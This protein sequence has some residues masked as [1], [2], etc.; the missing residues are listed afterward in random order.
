M[1]R[2]ADALPG[3]TWYIC[4]EESNNQRTCENNINSERLYVH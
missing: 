2:F 4:S 3:D 1:L